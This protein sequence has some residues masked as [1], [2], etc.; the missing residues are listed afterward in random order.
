MC[1][2]K[3]IFSVLT[4]A[5]TPSNLF[6][7]FYQEFYL[8]VPSSLLPTPGPEGWWD[9]VSPNNVSLNVPSGIFDSMDNGIPW[10]SVPWAML[11]LVDVP[12]PKLSQTGLS[13]GQVP[14]QGR[15][16]LVRDTTSKVR[17]FQGWD[18][19]IKGCI[20]QGTQC[21]RDGSSEHPRYFV[22]GHIV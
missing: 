5:F 16:I 13:R 12:V 3:K 2:R 9:D 10:C 7:H 22:R 19:L 15:D 1:G 6:H 4:L 14:V 21:P 17:I 11:P 18:T 8:N 20:V